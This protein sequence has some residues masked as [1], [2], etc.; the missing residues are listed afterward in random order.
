MMKLLRA[1]GAAAALLLSMS[2][3]SAE[4]D[5][6]PQLQ[7]VTVNGQ[8]LFELGK[9]EGKPLEV[10]PAVPMRVECTFTNKGDKA[11]E[12]PFLVFLHLDNGATVLASD[13]SPAKPTTAWTKDKEIT[14]AT[15]IAF[16]AFRGEAVKVYL[17]LYRGADRIS[18]IN[19][20]LDYQQRLPVGTIKLGNGAAT[21]DAPAPSTNPAA[22]PVE[23]PYPDK[24]GEYSWKE[25]HEQVRARVA[26]GKADL[27]FIGDSVFQNF[28]GEPKAKRPRGAETWDKYYGRRQAVNLGF[29]YDHTQHVLWRLEHGELEGI[30]PKVAV[31]MIGANNAMRDYTTEQTAEGVRAVLDLAGRKLPQT[32]FLVVGIL[33]FG[34]APYQKAR[35]TNALIAKSDD[36]QRIHFIDVGGRFLK[37]DGAIDKDLLADPLS[38]SA[39]GYRVLAD[40]IEPKL[41]ELLGAKPIK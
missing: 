5:F 40:A 8:A 10:D 28:G 26:T 24:T 33:P 36:G 39:K 21:A 37:P 20:G 2:A 32:K 35:D 1:A 16:G 19:E 29:G 30:A 41:A 14:D 17:G 3:A 4:D 13:Y 12:D 15:V 23:N 25:R 31:L 9:G 34:S 22:L 18:L 7:K 11:G 27:V 6:K 38:P